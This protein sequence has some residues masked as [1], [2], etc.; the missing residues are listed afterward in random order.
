[1]WSSN[2]RD[3]KVGGDQYQFLKILNG[4]E[5]IDPNIFFKNKT[6][7]RTRGHDFTLVKGQSRLDV[8]KYYFFHRTVNE[9]QLI[10]C[11]PVGNMF[12]NRIDNYLVRAG[13]V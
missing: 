1:M 10:V 4:H 7:K 11:M 9:C 13:Y 12:K 2:T 5:N 6:G 3:E 8:R